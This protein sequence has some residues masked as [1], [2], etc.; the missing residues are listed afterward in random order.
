MAEYIE[1]EE[2]VKVAEKYGLVNG[3][4]LGRHTGLADC[5][6]SEIADI[7]TADVAPVVHGQWGKDNRCSICHHEA[8]YTVENIRTEYDWTFVD[9]GDEEEIPTGEVLYDKVYVKS[10]FC[11]ACG[12]KMDLEE[13]K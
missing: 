2:A 12:A 13:E 10:R 8:I 9:G 6:A 5:I 11:L 3:S 7:P 4:A 1:R